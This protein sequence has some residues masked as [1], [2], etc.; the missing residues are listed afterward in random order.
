MLTVTIWVVVAV[1]IWLVSAWFSPP[2][3]SPR[4]EIHMM[5]SLVAVAW[6]IFLAIAALTSP[7]WMI[8]IVGWAWK[9]LNVYVWRRR[10]ERHLVAA[11]RSCSD[12]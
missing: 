10:H 12:E 9:K 3:F 4:S 11:Q 2:E 5:W 7:I 8:A 1:V 6:P